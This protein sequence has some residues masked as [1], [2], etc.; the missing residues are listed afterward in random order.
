M[1]WKVLDR[2]V[3]DCIEESH[4]LFTPLKE[5]IKNRDV[6]EYMALQKYNDPQLYRSPTEFAAVASVL[7]F[8]KKFPFG[9]VASIDP[10]LTAKEKFF[11]A[12]RLCRATNKRLKHFRRFPHRLEHKNSRPGFNWIFHSARRLIGNWLGPLDLNKIYDHTRHGPGGSIG[13]TGDGTTAYFK[14]AVTPYTVSSGA[15][16]YAEAAILA[17]PLWRRCLLNQCS[18]IGDGVP[19]VAESRPIVTSLLKVVDYNKVTFVLKTALTHRGIAIEP[20]MSIYL[21]LGVGDCMADC[22][23]HAGTDIRS[24]TRNQ[25]LA[26]EGSIWKGSFW[27]CPV[28]M[29]LTMA[30]DTNCIELVRELFPDDWYSLLN[31]LRSPYGLLEGKYYLYS[32]FSSM[33]NG[34]TFPLETMIFKALAESTAM[35]CGFSPKDVSIYGDDII[36]PRGV[37]L[38]LIDILAFAGFKINNDKTFLFGPFRESCGTDWFEGVDVRP[39]FLKREIKNDSDLVFITNSLGGLHSL[40]D[41]NIPLSANGG[42]DPWV[43]C[44]PKAIGFCYDSISQDIRS[45][46]LGPRVEDLE[47]HLH[48]PWDQAQKSRLVLWNRDVQAW[49]YYSAKSKTI[50]YSGRPGPLYLQMIQNCSSDDKSVPILGPREIMYLSS[51]HADLAA[52]C[53]VGSGGSLTAVSFR[54][55]TKVSLTAQVSN[56]WRID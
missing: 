12:E 9:K 17:D 20:T 8:L 2:L 18:I 49:S 14:Y 36:C 7:S 33:G 39:F 56:G 19:S 23:R 50:T 13:V 4:I 29:D 21:Q 51:F 46:L 45:N 37:A 32:K 3:D 5:C 26:R 44:F 48:C 43:R 42:R 41:Y 15:L 47:G 1:P 52:V 16:P 54:N 6:L 28:T 34:F 10:E 53:V 25:N 24:Q 22:L 31:S 38:K 27:D 40:Y 35:Y 30:S 55:R 11:E